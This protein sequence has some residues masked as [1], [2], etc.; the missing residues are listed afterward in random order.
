MHVG[1]LGPSMAAV[2]LVGCFCA[3]LLLRGLWALLES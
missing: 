2:C 3:E 1:L